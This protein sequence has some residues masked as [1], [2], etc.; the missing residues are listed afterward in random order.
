M[1]QTV[2]VIN[3]GSSS[4]KY[5]LVDPETGEAIAKGLVE[6]I[7][8]P[9]GKI[10]HT[11]GDD[12][13]IEEIP[14]ADH[15]VGMREVLRL[16]D[17]KGPKLAE[18]GIVAVG[19]RIVQG[20]KYFDG[21][22]VI[23]DEVRNLIEELCPMAPLHN[24][25]HL[26]GIDVARELMPEIPHVAVFDTAFFQALPEKAYTY[27]LNAEVAEKYA[28]RRYGAHGTSHQFVS[29]EVAKYLGRDDLKQI[30]MHLGNG[31]SV[32]AVLNGKPIDTSMGLTPLEG[33]MM[34]TR[35]GDIDPAVVFH[36]ARQGGM[37]IDEIDTLFNK[38]SGMKGLTGESDMRSVWEMIFNDDDK[39]AQH[40]ARVAMD[41]YINR[42]LKYVGSYTAELGGLDVI[43]FTAGIGENDWD[44]RK[45]LAQAL[46]PFGVKIDLA[47]NDGRIGEP[48]VIST[49]DSKVTLLV[50]PTNEEFAIARLARE[51][52]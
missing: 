20:G 33:L 42:L 12:V 11:H 18:A 7:G 32:S 27:A 41:V 2:L 17:N 13:T 43:T 6:R 9:V 52:I 49:P 19:H 25:A 16:F 29:R 28:V 45:E 10:K 36:L 37:T 44:V 50:Y 46:E 24:P 1:S 14:I 48:R 22:A 26:K 8:D 40:K 30:V 23:N 51:V 21:P 4:I 38:Q 39:E 35:T 15:E 47:A 31:A 34:G 3:S 5:Q